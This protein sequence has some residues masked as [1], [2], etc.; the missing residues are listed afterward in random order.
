MSEFQYYEWQTLDRPLNAEQIAKVKKLSSHMDRVT[1]TSAVVTYAY[2]DFK[3]DPLD[4][5]ARFFDVF[6]YHANWGSKIVAFR[7]PQDAFT[8]KDLEPYLIENCVELKRL[9]DFWILSL[10]LVKE[11]ADFAWVDPDDEA[12]SVSQIAEIRRQLL[13]KDF[14]AL[15]LMWL[16]RVSQHLVDASDGAEDDDDEIDDEID[17][18]VGQAPLI[19]AGLKTLDAALAQLCSFFEVDPHLVAAAAQ[20]SAQKKKPSREEIRAAIKALPRTECDDFLL[21]LF[22]DEAQAG[23]A[24]RARLSLTPKTTQ[25][26]G[27]SAAQL[28][29]DA[30]KFA[31][32]TRRREEEKARAARNAAFDDLAKRESQVWEEIHELVAR[33][34]TLARD[35]AAQRIKELHELAQH[36]GTLTAFQAKLHH[37]IERSGNS[38]ALL[39]RLKTLSIEL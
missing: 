2:G 1:S 11:E 17:D 21:R 5:L 7:F 26:T 23:D 30:R 33:K 24:L 8:S 4:V 20:H 19:P 18:L 25:T 9:G 28:M 34:T 36:R 6:L 14:R 39:T 35:K 27:I 38:R 31:E 15:Y 29:E 12:N 13:Q 16:A 3:Y 32:K 37:L 10:T 22:D